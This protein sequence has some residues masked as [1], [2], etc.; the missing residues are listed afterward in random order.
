MINHRAAR[1]ALQAHVLATVLASTGHV[2]LAATATGYTRTVGSFVDDGF[3]IGMEVTPSGFAANAIDVVTDVSP[4]TL[5]TATVHAT[6]S[7]A[8][9][10]ALTARLPQRR[11]F[12]GTLDPVPGRSSMRFEYVPAAHGAIAGNGV[13]TYGVDTGLYVVTLLAPTDCG[14]DLFDATLQPILDRCAPST[15]LAAGAKVLTVPWSASSRRGPVL[16][17]ATAGQSYAQATIPWQAF[18]RTT[19]LP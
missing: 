6:E 7:V 15:K 10:R 3:V 13:S 5:T 11:A 19:V 1:E 12:G 14:E 2:A 16:P 8:G 9:A 17:Y 4:L 18:S